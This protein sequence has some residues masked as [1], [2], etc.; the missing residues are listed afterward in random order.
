MGYT[1][2]E[3]IQDGLNPRLD[4]LQKLQVWD[5]PGRI[6]P[7]SVV[8]FAYD[9]WISTV[10]PEVTLNR[11]VVTAGYTVDYTNGKVTF[12]SPTV[13]L[14]QGDEVTCSYTFRWFTDDI[15]TDFLNLALS[16]F[17]NRNPVSNYT[18]ETMPLDWK[19][20]VVDNAYKL[21]LETMLLDLT[22]WK[23]RLV[24]QD[25][26]AASTFAQNLINGIEN[27]WSRWRKGRRALA[28][29]SIS[30]GRWRQSQTPSDSNWQQYTCV[31]A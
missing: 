30:S 31:R 10:T 5:E 13:A 21:A 17:N 29:R 23:A 2:A 11:D 16:E 6:R 1:A 7:A 24:F 18:L 26:S 19:F 12:A 14:E 28:P 15:L 8:D 22:T 25:P 4:I 3:L 20:I 9:D 27:R